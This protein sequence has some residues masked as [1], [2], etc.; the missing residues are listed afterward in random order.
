[1]LTTTPAIAG[2]FLYSKTTHQPERNHIMIVKPTPAPADPSKVC[3][4][5]GLYDPDVHVCCA[6]D[7][8]ISEEES[9]L[10]TC[11]SWEPKHI[12]ITC[13]HFDP[14]TNECWFE[15]HDMSEEE[16]MTRTCESWEPKKEV[17]LQP[18]GS[19]KMQAR[20][21]IGAE[22]VNTDA[23]VQLQ[24][25]CDEAEPCKAKLTFQYQ[26]KQEEQLPPGA[27]CFNCEH[28]DKMSLNCRLKKSDAVLTF[29]RSQHE[30]CGSWEREKDHGVTL[31]VVDPEEDKKQK[32]AQVQ[33]CLVAKEKGWRRGYMMAELHMMCDAASQ[34]LPDRKPQWE[35]L[36]NIL[37][38]A[39]RALWARNDQDKKESKA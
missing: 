14:D 6:D 16:S 29:M 19:L 30:Y 33:K 20:E 15:E 39:L 35:R 23:V 1:M 12:C 9:K 25:L 2:V 37:E 28:R 26:K 10:W 18:D 36:R 17:P 3:K 21:T 7:C 32:E 4:T 13:G 27:C 31:R 11:G 5:C 38:D 34:L 24:K 8:L 22:T